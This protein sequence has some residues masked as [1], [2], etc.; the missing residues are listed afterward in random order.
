ML[1]S[2]Q[3]GQVR[4]DVNADDCVSANVSA[5]ADDV[6]VSF[7]VE[8]NQGSLN[9]NGPLWRMLEVQNI[10]TNATLMSN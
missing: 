8:R 4:S 7:E 2:D 6:G 1:L 9:E 5:D 10:T 3:Q